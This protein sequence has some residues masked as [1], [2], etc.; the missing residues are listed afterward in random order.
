[1]RSF[2]VLALAFTACAPPPAPPQP[3]SDPTA[4]A[5]YPEAVRQLTSMSRDAEALFRSGKFD[6]ASAIVTAG[7]PLENRLL[8]VPH[9]TLPAMEAA[10][11]L[12][13]LY[14]RMLLRNQ[15]YGWA[16]TFFQ[17]NVTRWK[18]WKPTTPE[19]DR[20]WKQAVAAV[21]ECDRRLTE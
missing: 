15:Q 4:E 2:L 21:A 9:P 19:N 13:D 16:R 17:K 11:D 10:S 8:S 6:Q 20:R 7:Q 12:D 3:V 1:V 14:G 18:T 5:W